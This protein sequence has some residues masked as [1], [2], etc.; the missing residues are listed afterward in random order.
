MT[1]VVERIAE[2]AIYEYDDYGDDQDDV[3]EGNYNASEEEEEDLMTIEQIETKYEKYRD[4]QMNTG[5]IAAK[6]WWI[7]INKF[8]GNEY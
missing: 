1:K 6:V 8:M 3:E 7:C 2:T 4:D 5:V